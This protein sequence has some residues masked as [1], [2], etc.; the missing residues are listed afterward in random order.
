MSENDDLGKIP[1]MVPDRDDVDSHLTNRRSQGQDIV[2]P[3]YYTEKV[4]VSTWSVRI[5]LTLLTLFVGAGGYGAYYMYG[6][7][8][9][10][11]RQ[12]DLRIGDLELRLAIAGES[13]EESDSNLM[14]NI[15]KTIE[16]Y[17]LLWAN[18]RANNRTFDDFKGELAKLSLTNEGQNEATANNSQQISITNQSLMNSDTKLNT[19]TNELVQVSQSVASVNASVETL[20]TMRS[21]LETLRQSLNSGD[22][23]VL[24][25]VGR[26]EYIEQSLESVNAHRL[27]INESLFRLQETIEALQRAANGSSSSL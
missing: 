9:T 10:D 22:S 3:S 5:M 13:A 24:G 6:I 20:S 25:L 11:L 23:T 21:D 1:P 14:V 8:Q 16:Q 19:L 4:K 15:E 17:D 26:L 2:R 12:A 27:Q 18:W 7:Y